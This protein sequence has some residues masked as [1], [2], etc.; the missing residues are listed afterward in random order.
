[1]SFVIDLT[2]TDFD[3]Y[4]NINSKKLDGKMGMV[5][6]TTSWCGHCNRLKKPYGDTAKILGGSFPMFNFDCEKYQEFSSKLGIN[7]YPTIKYIVKSGKLSIDF[8]GE[9]TV[10]SLLDDICKKSKQ[11]R[12]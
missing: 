1:M 6:F 9:R 8:S 2:P 4:G 5:A 11:C 12:R 7:G 3:K 10:D